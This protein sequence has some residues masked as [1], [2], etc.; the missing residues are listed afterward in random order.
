V[1][2]EY[3]VKK[4]KMVFIVTAFGAGPLVAYAFLVFSLYVA[5]YHPSQRNWF[6]IIFFT[7]FTGG[8]FW[9]WRFIYNL[10]HRYEVDGDVLIIRRGRGSKRVELKSLEK[11]FVDKGL[12]KFRD[13]TGKQYY[14][15]PD[16]ADFN[17]LVPLFEP[18]HRKV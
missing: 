6:L 4:P 5:V 9:T 11:L 13:G 1:S 14:I 3:K 10:T 2:K 18:Y 8:G 7:V 12:I 15:T 17:E 16:F